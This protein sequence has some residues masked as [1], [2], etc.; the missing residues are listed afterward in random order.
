MLD[1]A[2]VRSLFCI[3][4]SPEKTTGG[5]CENQNTDT[6]SGYITRPSEELLELLVGQFAGAYRM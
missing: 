3:V 2:L 5:L 4:E 1:R 6:E